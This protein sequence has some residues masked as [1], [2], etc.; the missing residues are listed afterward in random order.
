VASR[1]SAF[2]SLI[3]RYTG[4]ADL[5]VITIPSKPEN[6]NSAGQKP[7]VWAS[8]TRPLSGD[9]AVALARL[10]PEIDAPVGALIKNDKVFSGPS[11]SACAGVCFNR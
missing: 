5:P 3:H 1:S 11:G 4:L 2:P 9:L 7:P 10:C 6:F 8:P